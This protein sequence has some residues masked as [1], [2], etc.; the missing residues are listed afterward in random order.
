MSDEVGAESPL[1]RHWEGTSDEP[2]GA[3]Q[4][5]RR[6]ASA[7]RRVIALLITS[8]APEDELGLAADRLEQ[9]ADHLATHPQKSKYEGH[10]ES[11]NA[12]SPVGF[13][14]QSPVIGLANPIAP[15]LTLEA[16]ETGRVQGSA[17]FG[18]AYEGP[19]GCVHGGW[20]AAAFDELLGF[21]HSVTGKPGMTGTLTIRYR[22][23]TPLFTRLR[24]DAWIEKTEGRKVWTKGE[25]HAGDALTAEAEGLF[26]TIDPS[27]FR[28]L[29]EA[30]NR[31]S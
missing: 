3:W 31:K 27:R 20:V 5:K 7:M 22:K 10:A 28:S 16:R 4:Q 12:G 21:A 14:D 1:T 6:L 17:I 25:V 18:Q 29:L 15:P 13:F 11:A 26:I 8:D 23:P 2:T 9:Y 30:R 19:P 24:F